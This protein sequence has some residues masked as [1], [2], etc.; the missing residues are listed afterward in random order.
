M[1]T[2]PG[3]ICLLSSSTISESALL[4]FGCEQ[5]QPANLCHLQN[6]SARS[7]APHAGTI[8][9]AVGP[10]ATSAQIGPRF[11]CWLAPKTTVRV[12]EQNKPHSTLI[13]FGVRRQT[14]EQEEDLEE[15]RANFA[16]SCGRARSGSFRFGLAQPVCVIEP[17]AFVELTPRQQQ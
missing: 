4:Q 12:G 5:Y 8:P 9:Q 10:Q 2:E 1:E 3:C 6:W 16:D 13:G 17:A 7:P 11:A 14:G 15:S